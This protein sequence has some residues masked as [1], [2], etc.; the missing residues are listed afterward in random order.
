MLAK[1]LDT[2]ETFKA[3]LLSPIFGSFS[4]RGTGAI[5]EVLEEG[6]LWLSP[7]WKSGLGAESS[8]LNSA[9]DAISTE[10]SATL[11]ETE[12]E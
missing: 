5:Q 8:P 9:S 3:Y 2:R 10:S 11:V 6:N 1:V 4:S 12:S 7:V